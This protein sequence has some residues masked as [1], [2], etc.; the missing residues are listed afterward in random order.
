MSRKQERR[1]RIRTN[2]VYELG[3]VLLEPLHHTY[4]SLDF[5][6][7]VMINHA[8]GADRLLVCL[9]VGVDLLMWMLFTTGDPG[10]GASW[11]HSFIKRDE[12]VMC[13]HFWLE[14]HLLAVATEGH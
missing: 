8:L 13:R 3:D 5:V 9:A 1:K 12:L 2:L 10:H 11:F 6:S 14:M 7:F 4:Q